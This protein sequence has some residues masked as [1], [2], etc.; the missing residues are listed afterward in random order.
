MLPKI[1]QRRLRAITK[2][3]FEKSSIAI[4]ILKN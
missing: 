4:A 2:E 3:Q 1:E